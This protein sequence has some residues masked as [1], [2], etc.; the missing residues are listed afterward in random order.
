MLAS[1]LFRIPY[2]LLQKGLT[3]FPAETSMY[4]KKGV[5]R[6]PAFGT[7]PS[8][9][10]V[11]RYKFILAYS[12]DRANPILRNIFK[13]C[14]RLDST[15]RIADFRVIYISTWLAYILLHNCYSFQVCF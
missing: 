2:I 11:F 9:Y 6:Q 14:A 10:L 7:L 13:C 5:K 3:L 15:V 1:F 4:K 12:A 8:G